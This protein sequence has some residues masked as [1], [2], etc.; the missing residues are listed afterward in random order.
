M[1]AKSS[2]I[3]QSSVNSN[4][5][6]LKW[7]RCVYMT[8]KEYK[9]KTHINQNMTCIKGITENVNNY[10]IDVIKNVASSL[11]NNKVPAPIYVMYAKKLDYNG[12]IFGDCI[13]EASSYSSLNNEISTILQSSFTLVNK[14]VTLRLQ[15]NIS[16][17][18]PSISESDLNNLR[19]NINNINNK[20]NQLKARLSE[21]S[22]LKSN[23]KCIND[24]NLEKY[25]N[26]SK[27]LFD[28]LDSLFSSELSKFNFAKNYEVYIYIPNLNKNK[29]YFSNIND[30]SLHNEWMYSFIK[31]DLLYNIIPISDP[32]IG[33]L[34]NLYDSPNSKTNQG[35]RNMIQNIIKIYISIQE[36]QYPFAK[37]LA[38]TCFKKGCVSD[39][40]EDLE[41]IV[42]GYTKDS[43]QRKLNSDSKAPYYP[44]K[45]LRQ[46]DY[47]VNMFN[48]DDQ[49][50][51]KL[52]EELLG[53]CF[54]D[55]NESFDK[56]DNSGKPPEKDIEPLLVNQ[57]KKCAVKYRY[58]E[59]GK[60][61][62]SDGTDKYS[63]A[64]NQKILGELSIRNNSY[65]GIQEVIFPLF[66]LN[67]KNVEVFNYITYMPWGNKL[68]TNDYVLNLSSELLEDN[69]LKSIN[70]NGDKYFLKIPTKNVPDELLHKICIFKNNNIYYTLSDT[71]FSDYYN[72][73]LIFEDFGKLKLY[74]YK[75]ENGEPS[76]TMIW[77]MIVTDIPS[78]VQPVSFG[79]N[80]ENGDL[81]AL[82]NGFNDMTSETLKKRVSDS[83]KTF[84]N[85]DIK[86]KEEESTV[87]EFIR[88]VNSIGYNLSGYD[89][90]KN[91]EKSKSNKIKYIPSNDD[92]LSKKLAIKTLP[93]V[94]NI[95]GN[96]EI[97]Y[98]DDKYSKFISNS[99]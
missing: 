39:Y 79:F 46:P 23:Y 72:K 11:P 88:Y 71:S 45:C 52:N 70:D 33:Q 36:K 61:N 63:V 65:P 51:K 98:D 68:L 60:F 81:I 75:I 30:Y 50:K 18:D 82:D 74:G 41:Q 73:K 12:T 32:M 64:Y 86:I 9:N 94:I 16:Q 54:D 95:S 4:D 84:L 44:T 85:S 47:S 28:N 48:D 20:I 92:E 57:F 10:V 22:N 59:I 29:F 99:M 8:H 89:D 3:E 58:E 5:D 26:I 43:G 55:F 13:D 80:I 27:R 6:L 97:L 15:L 53:N 24:D 35:F 1:G 19:N 87:S 93:Y 25:L 91:N 7:K 37:E 66:R 2:T 40:G 14:L 96:N 78:A 77:S 90:G 31:N 67:D 62:S 49:F 34:M 42:P 76:L 83:K 69:S 21:I 17:N 38:R 56:L